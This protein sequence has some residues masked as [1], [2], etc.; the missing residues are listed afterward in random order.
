MGFE[1]SK[2]AYF[3]FANAQKDRK[4]FEDRL[5]FEKV[6]LSH[7]GDISWII[8]YYKSYCRLFHNSYS[9]PESGSECDYCRYRASAQTIEK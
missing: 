1:V 7:E 3:V 5:D 9:L 8:V 6:L 2:T 4:C